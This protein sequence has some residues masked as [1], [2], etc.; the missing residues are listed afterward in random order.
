M[1]SKPYFY[2]TIFV[3]FVFIF[4]CAMVGGGDE[5][6]GGERLVHA[7]EWVS[8]YVLPWGILWLLYKIYNKK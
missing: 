5:F 6:F 8:R 2:G 3:L 7:F 4:I 1:N